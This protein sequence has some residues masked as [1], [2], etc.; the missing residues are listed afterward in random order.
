M[1][2]VESDTGYFGP[3]P[4]ALFDEVKR[5]FMERARSAIALLPETTNVRCD[6]P[7][8]AKA[9]Y[10]GRARFEQAVGKLKRFKRI[11]LRCEK[12]K[13]NFPLSFPSCHIR[14]DQIRPGRLKP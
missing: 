9:F 6:G 8:F 1:R 5:R 2:P 3:V 13:R 4:P 12:T 7:F 11:A 14:L 10:K